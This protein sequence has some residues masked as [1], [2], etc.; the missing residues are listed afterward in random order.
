M[1]LSAS[2]V[3]SGNYAA[4][5]AATTSFT[6]GKEATTDAVVASSA[7][8]EPGQSV[9]LTAT[10]KPATSGAPSGT[11]TF[12]DNGNPIGSAV[13]L[14]SGAA[15]IQTTALTPGQSNVISVSYSGDGNFLPGAA[16]MS[17]PSTITVAQLDFTLGNM[18]GASQSV[19]PGDAAMYSFT[20]APT[21]GVYPGAV[22][23][24]ATGLP[25]GATAIFSPASIAADGGAQTVTLTVQTATGVPQAIAPQSRRNGLIAFA[26]FFLPLAGTRRMRRAAQ[27]LGRRTCLALFLLLSLG[28]VAGLTGCGGGN[29]SFGHAQNYNITVT[30]TSG[31]VQHTSNVTLQVQ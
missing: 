13:T 14:V 21:F 4:A 22:N 7:T 24:T 23:F 30:V 6:V 16:A 29:S 15:Q 18:G 9:T 27:R 1:V 3:A 26:L 12:Y 31:A 2:Q 25:L 28:A 8:I 20:L 19:A 5:T 11:V 10:I 17:S